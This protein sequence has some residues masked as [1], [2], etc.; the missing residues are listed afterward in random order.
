MPSLNLDANIWSQRHGCNI[1]FIYLDANMCCMGQKQHK[2]FKTTEP[3]F[4]F[5]WTVA[6]KS[7]CCSTFLV[8][9]FNKAT[10]TEL[11]IKMKSLSIKY[12]FCNLIFLKCA[13]VFKIY[14]LFTRREDHIFFKGIHVSK[15]CKRSDVQW[16]HRGGQKWWAVSSIRS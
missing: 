13:F 10:V 2:G 4:L 12:W 1:F 16:G 6:L 9:V 11:Y 15:V 8:Y 5:G 14:F 7:W 3:F